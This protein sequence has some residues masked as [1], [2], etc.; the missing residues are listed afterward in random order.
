MDHSLPSKWLSQKSKMAATGPKMAQIFRDFRILILNTFALQNDSEI[1]KK[2][3]F[4][5]KGL[6][7]V[8]LAISRNFEHLGPF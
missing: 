8:K 7:Q 5:A 1:I 3:N 6:P 4:R 2:W